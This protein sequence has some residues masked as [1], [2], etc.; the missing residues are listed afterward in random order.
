MN[1]AAAAKAIRAERRAIWEDIGRPDPPQY[2]AKGRQS[3]VSMTMLAMSLLRHTPWSDLWAE[4]YF[5]RMQ[6][7]FAYPANLSVEERAEFIKSKWQLWA[8]LK[9]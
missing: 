3:G 9:S 1:Y 6:N 2:R 8:T 4:D 7:F 5:K